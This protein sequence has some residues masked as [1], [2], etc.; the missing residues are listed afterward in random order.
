[1]S[2]ASDLVAAA[3]LVWMIDARPREIFANADLIAPIHLIVS[4][5]GFSAFAARTGGVDLR[6]LQEVAYATYPEASL[7]VARGLFD[8]PRV[9]AAFRKRAEAPDGRAID[10][11]RAASGGELQPITRAWGTVHEHREQLA[12]FGREAIALERGKFGPLRV[13]EAFAQERLKKSKPA[14][15]DTPLARAAELVGDAPFRG[16][17]PG[18]FED[19]WG[20][21]LG[22]LVRASTAIGVGVRPGKDGA[23]DATLVLLGGWNDLAEKAAIHLEAAF[24]R[25]MD[26]PLARLCGGDKPRAGPTTHGAADA[27]TLKVTLDAMSVAR[28][29]R[30][31]TAANVDEIMSY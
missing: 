14:L 1:V 12:I 27:I 23:L 19:E 16:F 4:E 20:H 31:A 30:A 29:L 13:A 21:A 10:G 8:P 28:G 6:Q 22:G 25:M 3:S 18:P 17:A 5:D 24:R 11:A 26:Q 2:P 7:I 15:R 9:E